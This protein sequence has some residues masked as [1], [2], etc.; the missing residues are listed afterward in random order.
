ML[1][2]PGICPDPLWELTALPCP[3]AGRGRERKGREMRE[4]EGKGKSGYSLGSGKVMVTS[5]VVI[6]L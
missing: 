3:L 1:L 6:G 5:N 2:W 4:K